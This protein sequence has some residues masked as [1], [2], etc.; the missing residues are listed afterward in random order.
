MSKQISGIKKPL[1]VSSLAVLGLVLAPLAVEH[2]TGAHV[3][4]IG[5][6]QAAGGPSGSGSGAM[7]G[8]GASGTGGHS[9][10]DAVPSAEEDEG[11][12]GKGSMQQGG[13][14]HGQGSYKDNM[15][16]GGGSGGPGEDSDAKGPRYGGGEG[17]ATHGGKPI[18]AQEGIPEVELGRLSVARSPEKVLLKALAEAL[19]NF[20]P[21]M[22]SL[23]DMTAENAANLLKTQYDTTVRIDSP[24][25]N[26]AL[27]QELLA[28]G[29]TQLPGVTPA[30]RNDLAA[31]L[32]GSAS[33]KTIAITEDTVKAVSIILGVEN[34]LTASD[35]TEIATKAEDVRAAISEGHGE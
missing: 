15:Q 24:L 33:D 34:N 10:T 25:E 2:T 8:Q 32:L 26:L 31:I 17:D 18:W 11:D 19:A 20:T 13:G 4:F 35:I 23:Y 22:V 12:G 3:S 5:T 28:D 21:E 6:A 7:G 30:S 9:S 27:Y 14:T 16:Q 1:I 29:S